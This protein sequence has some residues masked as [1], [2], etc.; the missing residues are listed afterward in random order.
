L[1]HMFMVAALPK[2]PQL[3]MHRI[4]PSGCWQPAS[5]CSI[6]EYMSAHQTIIAILANINRGRRNKILI[7]RNKR[8]NRKI[9]CANTAQTDF[10]NESG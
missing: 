3:L 8:H 1:E 6:T 4:G 7:F 10:L 9:C 5:L 2:K